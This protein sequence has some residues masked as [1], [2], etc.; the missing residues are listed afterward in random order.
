[1]RLAVNI[2]CLNGIAAAQCVELLLR[3]GLFTGLISQYA[4][5]PNYCYK[6]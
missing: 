5:R 2:C 4:E 1:M 6:K 3:V